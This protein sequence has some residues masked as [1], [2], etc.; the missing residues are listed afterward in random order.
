M[1]K[2][3]LL[4]FIIAVI[5]ASCGQT[6]EEKQQLSR[7]ERAELRKKD[8]LALKVAVMPTF[9][10]LPLYLAKDERL[11][12]T[13]GVDVHLKCFTAQMDCDTAI[14]GHTAE[15]IVSELVSTGRMIRRGTPLKYLT[16]TD[17]YWQLI[18]NRTARISQVNQLGDKMVAMSRYSA[19]DFFTDK[20]LRGVKTKA[21]VFRIQINDV[22]VRLDMM[23][24]NMMDAAWM[25]EPQ[26]TCARRRSNNVIADTKNM[27][28]K[29]GV[30][31]FRS[32]C[33]RDNRR[34]KQIKA[35]S[36][37][38]NR[39]C[40][41]INKNGIRYYASL[42]L[43]YY[44]LDATMVKALPK[45]EFRHIEKPNSLDIENANKW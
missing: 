9:D 32:D 36:E 31:A 44:K 34:T 15:G 41:S 7:E 18:T 21:K 30:I 10:C 16:S 24:N 28:Y 45:M 38:Y 1:R 8:S 5:M 22:N 40:D 26:A 3:C 25:T 20:V 6:Y 27:K 19:T 39:A 13:L 23:L 42:L 17:A 2:F 29:F 33:Y 37:A 12:D 11:F 35:F 4:A 14:M 43:K